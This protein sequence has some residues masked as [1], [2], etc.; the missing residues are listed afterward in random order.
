M[1][2]KGHAN[3]CIAT[4]MESP[5]LLSWEG[6]HG[7]PRIISITLLL[8]SSKS[9]VAVAF[10][11]LTPL[12]NPTWPKSNYS[13]LAPNPFQARTS[14]STQKTTSPTMDPSETTFSAPAVVGDAGVVVKDP[15]VIAGRVEVPLT[16]TCGTV[17]VV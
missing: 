6:L 10:F 7:A 16:V 11:R 8:L 1:Q 13:S 2:R 9:T 4:Y 17:N 12:P 5:R 14:P 15:D 3:A